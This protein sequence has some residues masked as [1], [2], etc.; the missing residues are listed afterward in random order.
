MQNTGIPPEP[1][2]TPKPKPK[3]QLSAKI[4]LASCV[5]V[6]V[7]GGF[8]FWWVALRDTAPPRAEAPVVASSDIPADAVVPSTA[9]GLWTVFEGVDTFAGYRIEEIFAGE[10]FSKTAVGRT[11]VVSGS[12]VVAGTTIR[13]V[14]ITA[15]LTQLESAAADRDATQQQGGLEIETYPTATFV[16][17][18]P[19]TLPSTPALGQELSIVA[20]G[21]LT[22]H[23]VTKPIELT[24][25]GTW[26]G[27]TISVG[28][29]A[30]VVLSDFDIVP[31]SSDLVGVEDEGEFEVELVFLWSAPVPAP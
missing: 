17:S 3:R 26:N 18:A 5:V 30:P 9:D 28:G 13:D 31:P 22:L 19:I 21:N 24:L 10:T 8:G 4:A 25:E 15:D 2:S 20:T 23:G 11:K 29:G 16:L 7:L 27:A 14:T 1:T 6:V 12:M